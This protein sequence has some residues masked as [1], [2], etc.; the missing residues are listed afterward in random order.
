MVINLPP[1]SYQ[2][3]LLYKKLLKKS[4][5]K[6]G[7][8][9]K[10]TCL[11]ETAKPLQE[12]IV[13][14]PFRDYT[15]HNPNHSKK[16]I[17][18][19]GAI[20]PNETLNELSA[21]EITVLIMSFYIHD[22]GMVLTQ[23]ERER[24]IRSTQF[25]EFLASRQ[26]FSQKL[27]VLREISKSAMGTELFDIE[28]SIFQVTEAALAEYIRPLHATHQRYQQ[29]IDTIKNSSGRNDLF[30]IDG[31]SFLEELILVCISHNLNSSCLLETN[32]IHNDRFNRSLII[33]GLSLNMQYCAAVLR[34]VDIIDF[35]RERTPKSIFDALGIANKRLP[36]FEISLKEW[37]KHLSVHSINITDD[38]L[39]ISGD[40][41]HPNIEHSIREFCSIIE[42]EIR[43]TTTILKQNTKNIA[44]KYWISLP[45][46]VRAN[47]RS[48]GYIYKDYSIK[49]NES[50]II[51]LLMGENLYLD[52]QIALRELIQN[53]IDACNV[54]KNYE[55][56]SYFPEIIVDTYQDKDE[57]RWLRVID[58]GIGMDEYV[59]S[60][61]FF[62][63]GNS[64]YNSGDFKKFAL[65][66]QINSFVP[67]S[68]FGIGMISVFMIGEALKVV[69]KNESSPRNDRLQRTLFIDG[70]NSL[71]VVTEQSDG[72]QGTIIEVLLRKEYSDSSSIKKL[73][74][75][76]KENIIRPKIKISLIQESNN[77][78]VI[79]HD[80]YIKLNNKI[81]PTLKLE[82]IET[83]Q[84]DL[85]RFSNIL[86][87]KAIF[88]FFK[89]D[90]N[91]LSYYD[92]QGKLT[93]GTYPL[94]ES[95]MFE[96]YL[97]GSRITVN[98]IL[99]RMKKIG[100]LY[101]FGKKFTN[102]VLDVEVKGISGIEYD[103]SRD[104]IYGKGLF[105]VRGEIF[106]TISKGL[107][108]LGIYGRLTPETKQILESVETRKMPTPPL[109]KDL[110]SKIKQIID[111]SKDW[112]IGIH[113][114]I[115]EDLGIS[116]SVATKYITAMLKMKMIKKSHSSTLDGSLTQTLSLDNL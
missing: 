31:V 65:N 26:E 89:T 90:S 77:K 111:N 88:F 46:N 27:S 53:S 72:P 108:E 86:E 79:T 109:D 96:K 24:T 47:I 34:L 104:R 93:W 2:E 85:G 87:G 75:F 38:E 115:A 113:K 44:E 13:A 32:G 10:V 97:G 55:E 73:F 15:L 116:N 9:E 5:P 18:L 100:S 51:N 69:T 28:T 80:N 12:L 8:A 49:L 102:F 99:M 33:N 98:G 82:N 78:S 22:L 94:K 6:D 83:V 40:S 61:F 42:E 11:I 29:L 107:K 41:K 71:A 14:G 95:F 112:E 50:A 59:L 45:F 39:V 16:L 92:L 74:G 101:N 70:V 103:V 58:N 106:K 48:I 63:V 110:V 56:L 81:L 37:N 105:K 60:N 54:R 68:R 43:N 25:L 21:L 19:S 62:K 66:K 67:I 23:T 36:G 52:S 91:K 57:R 76:I 4:T 84:I 35:D 64:Y 114:R 30:E 17:H 1:E 3:T 7:L 20:I